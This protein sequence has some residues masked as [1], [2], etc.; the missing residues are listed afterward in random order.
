MQDRGVPDRGIADIIIQ[1]LKGTTVVVPFA[2]ISRSAKE[3]GR[4]ELA[5]LVSFYLN[6]KIIISQLFWNYKKLNGD[7]E[8]V[9]GRKI[10]VNIAPEKIIAYPHSLGCCC[11]YFHFSCMNSIPGSFHEFS[12]N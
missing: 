9:A 3:E 1:K 10:H 4:K 6:M 7:R 2:E 11:E 12:S 8:Y 5:T